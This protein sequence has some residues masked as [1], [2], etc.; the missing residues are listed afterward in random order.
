MGCVISLTIPTLFRSI[1]S[2]TVLKSRKLKCLKSAWSAKREVLGL[3]IYQVRVF[4]LHLNSRLHDILLFPKMVD[5]L[6][7]YLI[8]YYYQQQ[9]FIYKSL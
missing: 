4:L 7:C 9:F 2:Y 3:V 1:L 5:W 6:L 8:G